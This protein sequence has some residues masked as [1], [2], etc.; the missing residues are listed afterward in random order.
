M[1]K[2]NQIVGDHKHAEDRQ[3]LIVTIG[4]LVLLGAMFMR[5][6]REVVGL[7]VVLVGIYLL[8]NLIVVVNSTFFLFEHPDRLHL[9]LHRVQT[10]DWH[11]KEVG[12]SEPARFRSSR[13]A[14]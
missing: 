5:G 6:F 14:S 2:K 4:L 8:L 11:I 13:S 9:W 10:G 12:V 7:A 1:R 3:R